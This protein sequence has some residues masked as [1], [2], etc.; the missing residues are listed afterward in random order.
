M[1]EYFY[2]PKGVHARREKAMAME[3]LTTG[4]GETSGF[5]IRDSEQDKLAAMRGELNRRAQEIQ[6][7]ALEECARG[8]VSQED[9][10]RTTV[11]DIVKRS[12]ARRAAEESNAGAMTPE[13]IEDLWKA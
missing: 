1:D 8:G 9:A 7:A 6:R 12:K 5:Q 10:V 11:S 13:E 3:Y 2:G 4:Q